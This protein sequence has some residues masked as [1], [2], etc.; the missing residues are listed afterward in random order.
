MPYKA[1]EVIKLLRL[2]GCSQAE[3]AKMGTMGV[4][5][6]GRLYRRET[7]GRQPAVVIRSLMNN[8]SEQTNLPWD[9]DAQNQVID[10]QERIRMRQFTELDQLF[11]FSS[12]V[13]IDD[14][15]QH[16]DPKEIVDNP[17][18]W[19]KALVGYF[20][21]WGMRNSNSAALV[22]K[23][24][25]YSDADWSRLTNTLK[26]LVELHKESEWAA[27]LGCKLEQ[28]SLAEKW[29]PLDPNSDERSSPEMAQ[30]LEDNL[31]RQKLINYNDL[32]PEVFE[33]P[34]SAMAIAS[35]FKERDSYPGILSRLQ[36]IDDRFKTLDG[37]R[38]LSQE[39]SNFDK[40]FADFFAWIEEDHRRIKDEEAA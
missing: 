20:F 13:M 26:H 34:A 16:S 25:R 23:Y 27:L 35:R 36:R 2:L 12:G 39:D 38:H 3:I 19:G 6:V 15:L 8:L 7:K 29:N 1:F 31:T 32:I 33:A 40:D 18:N 14:L 24:S 37:I 11:G 9:I 30:W 5:N 21:L 10:I 17:G 22:M 4:A 28:N